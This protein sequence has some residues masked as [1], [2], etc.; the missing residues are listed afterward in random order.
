MSLTDSS[1]SFSLAWAEMYLTIATIA[2][3]FDFKIQ[4]VEA[5]DFEMESDQFLIGTKEESRM[6]AYV[7]SRQ[8]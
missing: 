6:K 7:V 8:D 1:V 4:N 3:R 5:A 2:Q